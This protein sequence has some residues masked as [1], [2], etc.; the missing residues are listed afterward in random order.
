M[1]TRRRRWKTL[2]NKMLPISEPFLPHSTLNN[3]QQNCTSL[4]FPGSRLK[5]NSSER[6]IF[7]ASLYL[8]PSLPT[9]LF[10]RAGDR[11]HIDTFAFYIFLQCRLQFKDCNC[12]SQSYA[13]ELVSVEITVLCRVCYYSFPSLQLISLSSSRCCRYGSKTVA[14]NGENRRKSDPRA[15]R[16]I[17]IWRRPELEYHQPHQSRPSCLR[18]RSWALPTFANPSMQRPL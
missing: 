7:S 8:G 11:L 10:A 6:I 15:I 5:T 2:Q 4:H 14:L 3:I 9:S 18:I 12:S 17:R 13:V 16:T 1:T